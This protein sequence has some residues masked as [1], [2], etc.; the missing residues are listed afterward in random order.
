MKEAVKENKESYFESS[1]VI[2][3]K[4]YFLKEVLLSTEYLESAH[5]KS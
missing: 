1:Y 2:L 5:P 4:L 3:C